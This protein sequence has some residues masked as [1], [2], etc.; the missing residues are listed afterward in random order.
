MNKRKFAAVLLGLMTV[1]G[2]TGCSE[3]VV[4]EIEIPV[5][6]TVVS[7]DKPDDIIIENEH[8]KLTLD[9][10]TTYFSI[11]DKDSNATWYSNPEDASKDP[12]AGGD[13]KNF[14]QSTMLVEYMNDIGVGAILNNYKYSIADTFF[15]IENGTDYITVNYTIGSPDKLF[16]IP[17]AITL[18]EL[19]GYLDLMDSSDARK[20]KE[21]YK[22]YDINKLS[23]SDEER[24][25]ELL[26]L[27]PDLANQVLY[28][29]RDTVQEYLKADMQDKFEAIG[30]TY[31]D[32]ERHMADTGAVNEKPQFNIPMTI[33]LDGED[34]LV[35]VPIPD[36]EWKEEYKLSNIS[37]LPMF[38]AGGV[39]D[40]GYM[41][42]PDG[43]GALIEFNNGKQT[44]SA[45]QTDIYGYDYGL[46]RDAMIQDN[47][48]AFG[49]YTITNNDDSVLCIIEEGAPFAHVKADVSGRGHSYNT[50]YST[51]DIMK[52][53]EVEPS[54]KSFQSIIMFDDNIPTT[55]LTQRYKFIDGDD[56][57]DIALEYRDYITEKYAL[58][59][60]SDD[61]GIPFYMDLIGAVNMTKQVWGVPKSVL[62]PLTTFEEATAVVN[63]I[64]D[65]VENL[66][67]IYTGAIDGGVNQAFLHNPDVL[68]ELGGTREFKDFAAAV[69]APVYL[70]ARI[71]SVYG[72]KGFSLNKDSSRHITREYTERHPFSMVWYGEKTWSGTYYNISPKSQVEGIEEITDL[73]NKTNI[74][75]VS[76]DDVGNMLL[77]DYDPKKASHREQ[78]IDTTVAA[79][80][81]A[82]AKEGV[83]IITH[84]GDEYVLSTSNT[85]LNM[86]LAGNKFAIVDYH[87]P[88][89]PMAI[90]GAVNYTGTPINL[91]GDFE[92]EFLRSIEYGA[93]LLFT[94]MDE[95]MT[96]LKNT[97]FTY[98]YAA[99]YDLIKAKALEYYNRYN[100]ELGHTAHMP[101]VNHQR[102]QENVFATTY[103]D[104]TKVYV[105]YSTND[106]T[107]DGNVIKATDFFVERG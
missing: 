89:Y 88:F 73:A 52:D 28:I 58:E 66:S 64:K 7:S 72:G 40:E 104:G 102:V 53:E 103:E 45:F 78:T 12:L 24:K 18:E 75:G 42:V 98:L 91:S 22:K 79:L 16:V 27:Y 65:T 31:E 86:D 56:Y 93:G 107:V 21:N 101:I 47:R 6:S 63:E 26:A 34:M 11:E 77:A 96:E 62:V 100:S 84:G 87:V 99:E 43:T 54:Y 25:D 90:K 61:S 37:L 8:L 13:T 30:Y 39:D 51:F 4:E 32:Y 85:I 49:A 92:Q 29:L 71:Q 23:K 1:V 67:V 82:G 15:E 9:P 35:E 83:D 69:N 44:Q 48:A 20:I 17:T 46:K 41:I 57:N 97:N 70:N 5:F 33:R 68:N 105:N 10:I 50:I 74:T 60:L 94:F 81:E 3:E 80:Q 55:T 59:Q 14:I 106:V 95:S 19:E 38:G 76:F 2:I 36:M